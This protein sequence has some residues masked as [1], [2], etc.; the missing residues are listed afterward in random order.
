M[1]DLLAQLYVV[2]FAQEMPDNVESSKS[3]TR[4]RSSSIPLGSTV[5]SAPLML[6]AFFNFFV[7]LLN[8]TLP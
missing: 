6:F 7:R 3:A 8:A 5:L 1:F 2:S 4:L